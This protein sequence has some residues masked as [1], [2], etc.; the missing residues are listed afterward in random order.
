MTP[1]SAIEHQ[2]KQQHR[3]PPVMEGDKRAEPPILEP[4]SK[5]RLSI[6]TTVDGQAPSKK[7]KTTSGTP[8]TQGDKS[9]NV[10]DINLIGLLD[11]DDVL[12]PFMDRFIDLDS[13]IKL[14]ISRLCQATGGGVTRL[15]FEHLPTPKGAGF[16]TMDGD[17]E[18]LEADVLLAAIYTIVEM[19][20]YFRANM[21]KP[22]E[23]IT[24]LRTAMTKSPIKKVFDVQ[25]PLTELSKSAG[26]KCPVSGT[27]EWKGDQTRDGS[28][29]LNLQL[30]AFRRMH[31]FTRKALTPEL[32]ELKGEVMVEKMLEVDEP[33]N[34]EM[35]QKAAMLKKMIIQ[36]RH[37]YMTEFVEILDDLDSLSC[38]L[39]E[40]AGIPFIWDP[41]PIPDDDEVDQ[42]GIN[43]MSDGEESLADRVNNSQFDDRE[44]GSDSEGSDA[45]RMKTLELKDLASDNDSRAD[46]MKLVIKVTDWLAGL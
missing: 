1:S 28:R 33:W 31:W 25:G 9:K 3:Q 7:P 45:T 17:Y 34:T 37:K 4:M 40:A 30:D 39:D 11:M 21:N 12:A 32:K 38:T 8:T 5:R 14:E 42:T 46:D 15:T 18:T 10:M 6:T 35:I 29:R 41:F 19:L 43:S 27:L 23:S 20:D 24:K 26:V 44:A 16:I 36:V 13:R 22:L 2:Q